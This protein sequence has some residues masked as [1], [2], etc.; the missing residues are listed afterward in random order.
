MIANIEK[1]DEKMNQLVHPPK[2]DTFMNRLNTLQY[3]ELKK[4]DESEEYLQ[5]FVY[6]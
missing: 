6:E 2:I 1:I 4:M 5:D 3:E